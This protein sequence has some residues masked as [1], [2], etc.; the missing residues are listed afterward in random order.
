MHELG[1]DSAPLDGLRHFGVDKRKRVAMAT[2]L[3]AAQ[4][5][6][7]E[8]LESL[9]GGVVADVDRNIHR[10]GGGIACAML[11]RWCECTGRTGGSSLG[12]ISS[13]AA[14]T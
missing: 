9:R 13:C 5:A 2:V 14:G 11:A 3:G 1:S 8:G 12:R 4:L 10:R 6:I 7:D